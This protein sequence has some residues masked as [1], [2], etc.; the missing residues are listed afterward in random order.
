MLAATYMY[1]RRCQAGSIDDGMLG[2]VA[3]YM[4]ESFMGKAIV[5]RP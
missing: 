1:Y 3:R 4:L 2:M 5:S